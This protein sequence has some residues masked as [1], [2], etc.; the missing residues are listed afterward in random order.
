MFIQYVRSVTCIVYF[1]ICI[2]ETLLMF[3]LHFLDFLIFFLEI[4]QW[5]TESPYMWSHLIFRLVDCVYVT[6]C[7]A[8]LK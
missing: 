8:Y 1:Y 3:L 6:L 4:H 7:L 5:V 2:S